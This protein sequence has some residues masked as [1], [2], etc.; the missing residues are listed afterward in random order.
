M[1]KHKLIFIFI[2]GL[3]SLLNSIVSANLLHDKFLKVLYINEESSSGLKNSGF[4]DLSNN[5]LFIN[6]SATGVDAHNWTWAVN[7]DWC[8]GSGTWVDPYIIE[9]ITIGTNSSFPCI[10]IINSNVYFILRNCMIY[11]NKHDKYIPFNYGIVLKNVNNSIITNNDCSYNRKG[12]F[13]YNSNN[14]TISQNVIYYNYDDGIYIT[15]FENQVKENKI[16]GNDIRYNYGNG[17]FIAGDNDLCSENLISENIISNNYLDGIILGGNQSIV[18]NNTVSN[19]YIGIRILLFGQ[20]EIFLN[21]LD[22]N[23]EGIR[24]SQSSE[25][26]IFRNIISN[27]KYSGI[28]VSY[29]K[30][31]NISENTIDNCNYGM[32]FFQS[33]Y[34]YISKNILKNNE[35]GIF[36]EAS[37]NNIISDNTFFDNSEC[38]REEGCEGN[39]F[40]NNSCMPQDLIF[41]MTIIVIIGIATFISIIIIIRKRKVHRKKADSKQEDIKD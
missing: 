3:I 14:N 15:N 41:I 13:L 37:N 25:N 4:W 40:L 20:N 39:T 22:N 32:R 7:Q 18:N 35:I 19:N 26:K 29:N 38:I 21:T 34:N 24:I 33:N 10:E 8:D 27:S 30:N 6:G 11:Y 1:K 16:V 31:N 9:N 2:I 28:M 23:D 36:L 12:I 17:V 5:T